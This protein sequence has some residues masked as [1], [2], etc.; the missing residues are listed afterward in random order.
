MRRKEI[1]KDDLPSTT[2]LLEKQETIHLLMVNR[3]DERKSP[4]SYKKILC[5]TAIPGNDVQ[6]LKHLA[7][8]MIP[9]A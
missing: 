9:T 8:N 1:D 6:D 3:N 2:E 7:E 4:L 5:P